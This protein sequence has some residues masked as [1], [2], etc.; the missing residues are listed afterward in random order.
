MLLTVR[1]HWK[2][3]YPFVTTHDEEDEE[4][5]ELSPLAKQLGASRKERE[6][7]VDS[8]DNIEASLART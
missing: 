6:R 5:Y 2:T 4:R 8:M 1:Q 7:F 3:H